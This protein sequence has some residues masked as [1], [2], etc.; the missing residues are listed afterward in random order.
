MFS[1]LSFLINVAA[2]LI[3]HQICKWF[4]KDA[5]SVMNLWKIPPYQ[6]GKENPGVAAPG[7]SPSKIVVYNELN[8]YLFACRHYSILIF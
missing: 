5:W 1:M 2:N 7:F 6:K 3:S 4:D 8:C